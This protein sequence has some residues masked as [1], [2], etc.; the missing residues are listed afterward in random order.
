[1][2]PS[3]RQSLIATSLPKETEDKLRVM[4]NLVIDRIMADYKLKRNFNQLNQ[5]L[6]Q[7]NERS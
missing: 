3:P 7:K 1:M 2:Q 5:D 6:I 4:A